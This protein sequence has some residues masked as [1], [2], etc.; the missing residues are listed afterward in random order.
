[1]DLQFVQGGIPFIG[2]T[3]T[4]R[5]PMMVLMWYDTQV[6]SSGEAPLEHGTRLF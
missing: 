2:R 5:R 1:M 3:L 6:F 4:L